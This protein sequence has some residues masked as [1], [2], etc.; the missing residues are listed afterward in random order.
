MRV[1]GFDP[2]A[3]LV[4]YL[5]EEVRR[6][7]TA[8]GC[9]SSAAGCGTSR[10]R[11]WRRRWD[12]VSRLARRSEQI[13]FDLTL[14]AELNLNDIKGVEAPSLD[15]W[16]HGRGA[17]RRHR[18]SGTDGRR[19]ADVPQP[20]AARQAGRQ[21]RPHRRRRPAVAQRRVVWWADEASDVR[22]PLRAARR[23][24]RP[25]RRVARRRRPRVEA[26][27]T[28]AYEGK[29]YRVADTVLQTEARRRKPRPV[30]YAGG[31]SEAAK[32]LI[33]RRC[34]AYVMHGDPPERVARED[35]GHVRAARAS[36]LA[37]DDLRR[38]RVH[39]RARHGSARRRAELDAHHR[40]AAVG[41]RVQQLPAVAGGHAVGAARVARR[42]LGLEPRPA[43][44]GWSARPSR[45]ATRV[46]EFEEAGVDLLLLQCSPQLEEMERFAAQVIKRREASI[47]ANG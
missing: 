28:S 26:K 39:D 13:G 14:V 3:R 45:C 21:H 8:T 7:A 19:A 29:F 40:R 24:L 1:V 17:R 36:G 5:E 27:T 9:R 2:H 15:A 12:Y 22:R 11:P 20:G 42:L 31:E 37:A 16:S 18:A 34:D 44:A 10:T 35:R 33:A 43:L 30:I 38:G 6:C 23:P 4:D 41:R 25:H 46:E 47:T 32:N